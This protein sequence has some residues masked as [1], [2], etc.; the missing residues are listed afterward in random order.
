MRARL[1]LR[2]VRAA[3]FSAVCVA[4]AVLGHTAAGGSGPVPWAVA[5]GGSAVAAAAVLLAGRERSTATIS[6]GLSALQ[7]LLHE[8]FALGD[9]AGTSLA[10]HPHVKGLG[11]SV[12]MLAAHLTATLITG[13]WLSRGEDALWSLL[14]SA[15]RRLLA[16]L[17]PPRPPSAPAPSVL[18]PASA[19]L[20]AGTVLRHSVS[21]RGPP[22]RTA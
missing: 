7:L 19:P 22:L 11:E 13:W 14:R 2:L 15:G 4:L 16:V 12:G 5:I 10:P 9:P 8:L 17:S 6:T 20:P 18:R 21:R 3:V 1:P